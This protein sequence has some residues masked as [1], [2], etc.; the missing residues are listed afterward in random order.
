M[1]TYNKQLVKTELEI[2]KMQAAGSLNA[3]VLEEVKKLIKPGVTTRELDE[4][5]EMI[6]RDHGGIPTFK[7]YPG[8]YPYPATLTISINEEMVHG[9]PSGRVL[10]EGDIVSVD[11]GTTLDGFIGDSAFTVG[12]GEIG[13]EQ[14]R[15]IQVTQESLYKGIEQMRP[16]KHVGDVGAAIQRYVEAAGYHV[17][18]QYTG[19]GVGREMHEPPQ[20]PN[21]GIPGQGMLLREGL[22]IAIEPMVLVGT[23][24]TRVLPDQWTVISADHSLTA[25]YEH[26]V[27]VTS[28]G[29]LI[30]T[31]RLER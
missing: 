5:A 7:G 30:L 8:P 14:K 18:K 15:L 6:I 20:V 31:Q 19:H 9:I 25:H 22:T 28:N 17:P 12:V 11:C 2:Q 21:F 13:T 1:I 23:F 10:K 3:L 4:T 27:A 16:G 24:Q 29:P 26:T